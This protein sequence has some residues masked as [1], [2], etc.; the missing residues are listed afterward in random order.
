MD[1]KER[2]YAEEEEEAILMPK[3]PKA[4]GG[5]IEEDFGRFSHRFG[6]LWAIYDSK[7]CEG[8]IR[9]IRGC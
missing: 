3:A 5:G 8:E 1:R 6:A 9:E 4:E 2:Q 7:S